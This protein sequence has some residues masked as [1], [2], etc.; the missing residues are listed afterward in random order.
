MPIQFHVQLVAT[1]KIQ[2]S[3]F[4]VLGERVYESTL[5]GVMGDNTISWNLQNQNGS[6]VASGLYI[7]MVQ[8]DGPNGSEKYFGKVIVLH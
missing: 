8:V 4:T 5:Q 6:G 2:L 1:G 3:L 7:F